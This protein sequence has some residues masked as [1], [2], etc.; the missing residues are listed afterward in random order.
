MFSGTAR[1]TSSVP[2]TSGDVLLV[3]LLALTAAA[4]PQPPLTRADSL[5]TLQGRVVEVT[6]ATPIGSASV[7]LRGT[8]RGTATGDD[9]RFLLGDVPAGTAQ[10]IIGRLGYR[11]D[12]VSVT[13]R[14]GTL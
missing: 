8:R 6:T 7:V 5:G 12:T 13:V 4:T 3:S 14:A 1:A 9:G 10:V 2:F 11:T